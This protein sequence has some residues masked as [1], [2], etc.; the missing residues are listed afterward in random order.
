M[1]TITAPQPISPTQPCSINQPV[2]AG[3]ESVTIDNLSSYLL[4]VSIGANVFFQSPITEMLYDISHT[5]QPV[6][7]TATA[8]PDDPGIA[9]VIAPTWYNAGETPDGNWPVALAGPAEVAAA[10]AAALLAQGVPNVLRSTTVFQSFAFTGTTPNLDIS[11]QASV[12]ITLGTFG[13]GLNCVAVFEYDDA[14]RLID[15]RYL[16]V[17]AT[18][19]VLGAYTWNIPTVGATMIIQRIA[20]PAPLAMHV[21]G[22]NRAPDQITTLGMETLPR[23]FSIVQAFPTALV[24]IAF[25]PTDGADPVTSFTGDITVEIST[26]TS[27]SAGYLGMEYVDAAGNLQRALRPLVASSIRFESVITHPRTFVRWIW[28]PQAV[29]AVV[30]HVDLAIIPS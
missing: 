19:N 9:G 11:E 22:T 17:P 4:E 8:L 14:S 23:L 18:A 7:I 13:T 29:S 30:Q 10:T 5:T 6:N 27:A 3:L 20:G 26:Q 2:S 24:P 21:T 16:S 1:S 12:Q 25:T 15:Q 28:E